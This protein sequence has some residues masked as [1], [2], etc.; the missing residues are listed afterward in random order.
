MPIRGAEDEQKAVQT[1]KWRY[2]TSYFPSTSLPGNGSSSAGVLLKGAGFAG[3]EDSIRFSSSMG[4]TSART[5]ASATR[6]SVVRA[7]YFTSVSLAEPA[8]SG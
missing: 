2:C 5:R 6:T 7:R 1:H 3:D 8:P 4:R